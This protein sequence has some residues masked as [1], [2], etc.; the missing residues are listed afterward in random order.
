MAFTLWS[1]RDLVHISDLHIGRDARTRRRAVALANELLEADVDHVAVTGNVT[2]SGRVGEWE[3]FRR[4]FA[5]LIAANRVT[6]V[7]GYHDRQG[8]DLARAIQNGPGVS[9]VSAEGLHLIRY[10]ST[11]SDD[12]AVPREQGR[13]T[14]DDVT[15][16]AAAVRRAPAGKLVVLLM[17]HQLLP[18]LSEHAPE[19][20]LSWLSRSYQQELERGNRL[21]AAVRGR[22]DLILQGHAPSPSAVTP[23]QGDQRAL[24]VFNAGS[25]TDVGQVRA[26]WHETGRLVGPPSWLAASAGK[27]GWFR[28]SRLK[29]LAGRLRQGAAPLHPS[30][31]LG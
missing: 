23:F 26:F 28:P 15:A 24:S 2:W 31:Q 12:L 20:M 17:H 11:G 8:D 9:V 30:S 29:W 25:S 4:I 3:C 14:D 16:I 13:V 22:C 1:V 18:L 21:L 27:S 5:P 6:V 7:P 10:D 19:R